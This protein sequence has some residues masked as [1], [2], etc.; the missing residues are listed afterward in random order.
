MPWP[1]TGKRRFSVPF[2]APGHPRPL[3]AFL[4]CLRQTWKSPLS[5]GR[6][7]ACFV[8]VHPCA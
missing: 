3:G 5:Q 1:G 8:L 7:F 4:H 6:G 2:P